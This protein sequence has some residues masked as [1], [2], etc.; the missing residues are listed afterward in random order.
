M[1]FKMA[2]AVKFYL[3]QYPFRKTMKNVLT[4]ALSLGLLAPTVYA[5]PVA[6]K[7]KVT[8]A[9]KPAV[10]AKPAIKGANQMNGE[11][12]KIGTTYTLGKTPPLNFTL[13]SAQFSVERVNI[14][15][16]THAPSADEK[17]LVLNFSVHNPN[18]EELNHNWSTVQFTVVD[19]Q[20]VNREYVNQV[21]DPLNRQNLGIDLKPAQKANGYTVIKVPAKGP[22]PKLIVE[23]KDGSDKGVLRYDLRNQVKALTAPFADPSDA[24][25]VTALKVV[26]G[27]MGKFYPSGQWDIKLDKIEYASGPLGE[28]EAE[29]GK[30]FLVVHVTFKNASSSDLTYNFSTL[31]P[32]LT[33][34]DGEK[35][36]W[37]QGM[38]KTTR[39]EGAN[40]ELKPGAEYTARFL[41]QIP[42]DLT[43]KTLTLSE[44]EARVY[45][46]DLAAK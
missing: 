38:L 9:K 23:Y 28:W 36:D 17:L 19:A 29:E 3:T 44:P 25:G 12:A 14:A 41:F 11:E 22:I 35:V 33:A 20:N 13:T 24:S 34:S 7:K 40:G 37:N 46:F 2:N 4:L 5:A 26:S 39:N 21:G 10:P 30:R 31:V 8:P 45:S 1:F 18:K 16:Y 43:G 6:P 42:A 27:E 15:D 32:E